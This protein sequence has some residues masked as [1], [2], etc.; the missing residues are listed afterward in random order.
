MSVTDFHNQQLGTLRVHIDTLGDISDS[1]GAAIARA[2]RVGALEEALDQAAS[3]VGLSQAL[4]RDAFAI[5]RA[6]VREATRSQ[7]K[8]SETA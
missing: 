8:L 3:Q 5:L 6:S 2:V 4:S 7:E 1:D